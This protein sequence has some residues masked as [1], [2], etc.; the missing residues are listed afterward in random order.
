MSTAPPRPARTRP[1]RWL[2]GAAGAAAL[3]T[4]FVGAFL[5]LL[6]TT[7]FVLLAALCFSRSSPRLEH[8]LLN[9]RRFGPL[10]Q[11][12]RA[13]QAIPLRAKRLA[14]A[15][16][17]LGSAWAAWVLPMRWGWIPALCCAAVAWWMW[18]LPSGPAATSP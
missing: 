12:W 6:P 14:W 9:H 4:G 2:W 3:L 8:W 11:D 10:I 18:R 17:A 13:H 16:M 5:P 7:P 15:M 1:H